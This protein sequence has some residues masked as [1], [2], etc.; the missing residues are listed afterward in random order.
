[1][2]EFKKETKP[3]EILAEIEKDETEINGKIWPDT[4]VQ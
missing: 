4:I 3:E 2:S 1:L